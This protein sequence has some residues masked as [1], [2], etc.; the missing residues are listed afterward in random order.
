[1]I[2]MIEL[3]THDGASFL[4]VV[5]EFVVEMAVG[6]AAGLAGAA[7]LIPLVGAAAAAERGALPGLAL[8]AAAALSTAPPSIAHGSGFLAVFIAG[9]FLGDANRAPFTAEIEVFH[10]L[11]RRPGGARRLRR[12]R[13]HDRL[14]DI[15]GGAP[16]PRLLLAVVLAFVARPLAVVGDD[17]DRP[18]Q[19]R[20]TA[21]H[22]LERPQGRGADPARRVRGARGRTGRR[23]PYELVFVVVLVSVVG[24]GTLVPLVARRLGIPM[25][26]HADV[27]RTSSS[28]KGR[29]TRIGVAGS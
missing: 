20:R 11:A 9:L 18:V 22:H 4:V 6:L 16:G 10:D 2:G 24:Q 28:R 1:M 21:L 7:L 23:A 5:E 26:D 19:P 13:P 14:T 29:T 12:A 15:L 3:A 17:P 27:P 25:R 8:L